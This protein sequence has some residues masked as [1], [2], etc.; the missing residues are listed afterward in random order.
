MTRPVFKNPLLEKEFSN[1][2]VIVFDLNGLIVDD[3]PLQRKAS[4]KAL[5]A[6]FEETGDAPQIND[7]Q[8][9]SI[10]VGHP[11]EAWLPNILK[12][13]LPEDKQK[14]FRAEKRAAYL[15]L[16]RKEA[17]SIV[18]EGFLD[19]VDAAEKQNKKRA[20]VTSSAPD[21]VAAVLGQGGLDVLDKFDIIVNAEQVKKKK[22]DPEG[23]LMVKNH[24]GQNLSYLVFEDSKAGVDAAF[25]AGMSC[26]A[27]PNRYTL[28]HDLSNATAI[29][30]SMGRDATV[31]ANF[32]HARPTPVSK[33]NALTN[34]PH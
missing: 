21:V 16:M 31:I 30:D 5:K 4:N 12:R 25:N 20:I 24:F 9:G 13:T 33:N 6:L 32:P 10:C 19:L 17:K 11:S 15:E 23:Y 7:E 18:R 8:W 3:E 26:F 1:A 34:T 2:D 14:L 28:D 27:V 22:P 29:I